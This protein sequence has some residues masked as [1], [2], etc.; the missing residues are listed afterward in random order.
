MS[1]TQ[2]ERQEIFCSVVMPVHNG[3]RFLQEAI[4]S[5]LNQTYKNLEFL[6]IENCST[7]LSLNI[8]KSFIDPR[9]KL[10][11]ND[12]CGQVQAYNRG[13]KEAKGEYV[14]I[15]DQDDLSDLKRFE[16]QLDFI[17]ANNIE[18]CGTFLNIIEENGKIIGKIEMPTNHLKIAD[19]LLYKNYTIFN[20]STC[21]KKDVIKEL[22]YFDIAL[23]PCAD[24][25]FYLKGISKFIYG[26]VNEYLY[27]WRQHPKQIS[28]RFAHEVQNYTIL[29][30]LNNCEHFPL[31]MEYTYKGLVYY[32]NNRLFQSLSLFGKA[33]IKD[34]VSKKLV[35]YILIILTGGIPLKILRKFNLVNSNLFNSLKK[36]L[37]KIFKWF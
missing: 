23:Y 2:I 10:I 25:D 14:F 34:R 32:Y 30:S 33:I 18:I 28:K 37:D 3:E 8:I 35:R 29:I 1:I 21:I 7:D 19:E 6:I 36:I 24:Y 15:H 26:N 20:S 4:E 12:D 16:I 9:I 27:Y 31:K 13:F 17:M 5:V 11:I 22:G